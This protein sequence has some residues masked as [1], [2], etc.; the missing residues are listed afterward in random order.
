MHE[1][2]KSRGKAALVDSVVAGLSVA[3]EVSVSLGLMEDTGLMSDLLETV[4]LCLPFA[5][6]AV[7]EG[8]SV[9]MKKKTPEAGM[10]D[11]VYRA[12]KTGAA[13]G[14]GAAVAAAGAAGAAIPVAVGVR[15]MLDK[16]R[17]R[18]LVGL[19]V[20]QRIE[21][22]RALQKAREARGQGRV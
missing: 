18:G 21:R 1:A 16:Y 19:R 6:V 12:A 9:L 7:T 22:V 13:M 4:S 15:L 20:R 3:D 5:V 17:A 8:G 11:A 2:S 14:A 10:Q